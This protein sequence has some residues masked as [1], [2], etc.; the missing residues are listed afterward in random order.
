MR[1]LEF[2]L[3]S[4]RAFASPWI[5]REHSGAFFISPRKM[6]F[7]R[8]KMDWLIDGRL[9]FPPACAR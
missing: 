7:D 5:V 2:S 3:V 8:K 6:L 1:R 9:Q 4:C